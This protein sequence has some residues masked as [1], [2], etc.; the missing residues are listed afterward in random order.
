MFI[1]AKTLYEALKTSSSSSEAQKDVDI[2]TSTTAYTL[3]GGMSGGTLWSACA[4]IED[5]PAKELRDMMKP[6]VLSP[7]KQFELQCSLATHFVTFQ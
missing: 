4:Q 1:S 5:T 6:F 7:S 2:D 3:K